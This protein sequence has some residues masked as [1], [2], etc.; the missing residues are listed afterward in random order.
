VLLYGFDFSRFRGA[1]DRAK[2]LREK[3]G[4]PETAKVVGHVGRFEPVKN[5]RFLLDAFAAALRHAPD[6]QLVL[7]GDGP[8]F[9]ET[10]QVAASL[11]IEKQ[12]LFSGTSSDVPAYMAIF[13]L[14]VLPSFSEGLGIVCVEAQA[15]GTPAIVSDVVPAEVEVIPGAV[16]HLS[17]DAGV[18]A[19]ADAI[20]RRLGEPRLAAQE[21]LSRVNAS[22][23]GIGRCV[24]ELDAIYRSELERSA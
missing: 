9:D 20:V 18:S 14:F 1:G 16:K 19:W 11:G 17:L 13:D 22:A 4:I 15:A 24:E 23:F 3:L 8:V 21:A 2:L 6:L 12:V 5:H 7:V 10:R